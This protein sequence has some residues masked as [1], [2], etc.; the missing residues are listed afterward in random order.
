L[1]HGTSST[2]RIAAIICLSREMTNR[3]WLF[4]LIPQ[5]ITG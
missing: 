1:R 4:Q 5:Q 2:H 3:F